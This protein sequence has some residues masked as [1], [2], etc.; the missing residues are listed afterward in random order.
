MMRRLMALGLALLLTVGMAGGCLAAEETP[1]ITMGGTVDGTYVEMPEGSYTAGG[2]FL[3]CHDE[4]MTDQGSHFNAVEAQDGSNTLLAGRSF[5][6]DYSLCGDGFH[7]ELEYT[8]YDGHAIITYAPAN[9]EG[10]LWRLLEEQ[11]PT[12]SVPVLLTLPEGGYD[13]YPVLLDLGTGELTD[14]PAASG[15]DLPKDI[16]SAVFSPDRSATLLRG[17]DGTPYYCNLAAGAVYDLD[18]LSGAHAD[19]CVLGGESICCLTAEPF[20][21]WTVALAGR[22]V[23]EIA[24]D[25]NGLLFLPEADRTQGGRFALGMDEAGNVFALDLFTGER[26]PIQGFVWP[27]EGTECVLS[28]DGERLCIYN[29]RYENEKLYVDAWVLDYAAGQ[30]LRVNTAGVEE[31]SPHGVYWSGNDRLT[32]LGDVP[33]ADAYWVYPL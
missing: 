12:G 19:V 27:G 3:V 28:P 15:I 30:M 10:G 32:I 17:G 4:R 13:G 1:A 26:T 21:A 16:R 22:A 7:I 2:L 11:A 29:Y 5:S 20:R 18:E 24:A 23:T 9:S 33:G 25:I 14:V 8:V 31:I 6:E